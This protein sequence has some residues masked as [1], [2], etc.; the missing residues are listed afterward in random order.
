MFLFEKEEEEEVDGAPAV[1]VFEPGVGCDEDD[2][3]SL[4]LLDAPV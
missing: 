2:D 1:V 4:E 3:N